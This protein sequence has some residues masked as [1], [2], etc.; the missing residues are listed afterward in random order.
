MTQGR[1]C[2]I[3]RGA[4][5]ITLLCILSACGSVPSLPQRSESENL[6][7]PPN[8]AALPAPPSELESL[9]VELERFL[10]P[11]CEGEWGYYA[12]EVDPDATLRW[13]ANTFRRQRWSDVTL[14]LPEPLPP[15]S[16]NWSVWHS[17][18]VTTTELVVLSLIPYYVQLAPTPTVTPTLTPTPAAEATPIPEV[19]ITP[20][21]T[22]VP[23]FTPTPLPPILSTYVLLRYCSFETTRDK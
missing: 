12:I 4:I 21:P 20:T 19:A 17:E 16:P 8:A 22:G 18:G 10:A 11:K 6:I 2:L 23:P 15:R 13:Y 9:V 5:L 14:D 7:A 3:H 1:D